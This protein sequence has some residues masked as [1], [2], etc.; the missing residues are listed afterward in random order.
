MRPAAPAAPVGEM[1][2]PFEAALRA[3]PTEYDDEAELG[4]VHQFPVIEDEEVDDAALLY[5]VGSAGDPAP[6]AFVHP[7][8]SEADALRGRR[9]RRQAASLGGEPMTP[10]TATPVARTVRPVV[11]EAAPLAVHPDGLGLVLLVGPLLGPVLFVPMTRTGTRRASTGVCSSSS[12]RR[13]GHE[14]GA[15]AG[16]ERARL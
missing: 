2:S 14:P 8:R 11:A 6:A 4:L 3:I 12:C 7:E 5:A 13:S 16:E 10:V 15:P 1:T 9:A